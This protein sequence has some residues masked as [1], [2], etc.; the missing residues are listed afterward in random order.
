MIY[1]YTKGYTLKSIFTDGFIATEGKRG[2]SHCFKVSDFVWLTAQQRFPKTALPNISNIPSSNL[3]L[4]Y[5]IKNLAVDY[6]AISASCEGLYRFGFSAEDTRLKRWW[7]SEERKHLINNALWRKMEG[8]AHKVGEEV[9]QY[10]I[11]T[12]DLDLRNFVLERLEKGRWVSVLDLL[13]DN[14]TDITGSAE[15]IVKALCEKADRWAGLY[16]I[17]QDDFRSAA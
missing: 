14:I 3:A 4:H 7:H 2:I 15:C 1:H 5:S 17:S 12:D 9:R 10:W 8:M 11:S 6:D 16:G 13:N